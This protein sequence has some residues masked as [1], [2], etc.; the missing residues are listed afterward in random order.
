LSIL[1]NQGEYKKKKKKKNPN[2]IEDL[3]V[4]NLVIEKAFVGDWRKERRGR[5][6]GLRRRDADSTGKAQ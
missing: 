6:P 5:G 3:E 1:G 4:L 2:K